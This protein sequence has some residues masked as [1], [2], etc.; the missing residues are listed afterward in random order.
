[1]I[2][3]EIVIDPSR[4]IEKYLSGFESHTKIV[5]FNTGVRKAYHHYA[6]NLSNNITRVFSKN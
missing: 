1:M 5:H 6:H 4:S 2:S 3:Y